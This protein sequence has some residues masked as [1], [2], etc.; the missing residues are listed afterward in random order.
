MHDYTQTKLGAYRFLWTDEKNYLVY[1]RSQVKAIE[2][3]VHLLIS[4]LLY[5]YILLQIWINK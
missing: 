3:H 4:V 2:A 1:W 5:Q